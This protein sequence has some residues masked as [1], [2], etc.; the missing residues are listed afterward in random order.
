LEKMTQMWH[1]AISDNHYRKYLYSG[2]IL[3]RPLCRVC[4]LSVLED[5]NDLAVL[6]FVL[7]AARFDFFNVPKLHCSDPKFGTFICS[8]SLLVTFWQ[9]WSCSTRSSSASGGAHLPKLHKHH[10]NQH[11]FSYSRCLATRRGCLNL[12]LNPWIVLAAIMAQSPCLHPAACLQS[13]RLDP[14]PVTPFMD[15]DP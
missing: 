15:L 1:T 12:A 11:S 2:V 8:E 6:L 9:D 7:G 4:P 5:S 13:A 10:A 3:I 14:Q